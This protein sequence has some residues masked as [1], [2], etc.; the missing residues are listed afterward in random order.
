M[1]LRYTG[2]GAHK[3]TSEV[4][5]F[6]LVSMNESKFIFGNPNSRV[7]LRKTEQREG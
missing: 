7:L 2:S 6:F 5:N 3:Q 4:S 1:L